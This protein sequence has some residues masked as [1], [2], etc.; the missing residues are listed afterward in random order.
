MVTSRPNVVIL[1]DYQEVAASYGDWGRLSCDV[2]FLHQPFANPG[3]AIEAL[4][5]VEII[6]AMRE[7]TRFPREV[8]AA[9]PRLKL[10]ITTGMRNAAIDVTAA[11]ELGVTVC[12]T[13]SPGHATA[14]LAF[15]LIQMLARGLYAE[16]GAT[17]RGRWQ[18]G[19]GRDLRGAT[20]GVIGL[21]R[22][23]GQVAGF[24]NA[25][26]MNVVAWSENLTDARADEIG[27][28][29]VSKQELLTNSDFV[30][31]HVRLSER[32]AGL[33][34]ADDLAAMKS[35]A[36]LVNTSRSRVVDQDALLDVIRSGGIAGAA[37]DVFDCEPLPTDHPLL[38]EPRILA[39]PHVGYVTRETYEIFYG[40]AVE[41]IA[42]WM[43]GHPIRVLE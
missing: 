34:D 39:T 27:V 19:L 5:H 7:R 2:S 21:G 9:L 33:L 38:H 22:L 14:E 40:Q 35:S 23:G 42:A 20:L 4:R 15:A 29:H 8:L 24:G 13:K 1:D 3:D 17:R 30:S 37:L 28:Q 12:G 41:D 36:F 26:G 6:V 43:N 16:V 32:S 11:R 31:I 25:F 10:L 18:V